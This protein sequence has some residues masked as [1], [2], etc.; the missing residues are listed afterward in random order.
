LPF[1]LAALLACALPSAQEPLAIARITWEDAAPVRTRLTAKGLS[2]DGF[3]AYVEKVHADNARRV[4]EGDLD[5]LVFYMLQS[6][7]FTSLPTIEPALS[8]KELVENMGNAERQ[9]FLSNGQTSLNRVPEPVVERA[10]ALQ[11][12]LN[13]PSRDLRVL[14]FREVVSAAFPN[15]ADRRAGVLRE[16]LRA[17]RFVYEKEF[18]A[19]RAVK[20]AEAVVE[21]YRTRGLSTDTE[22]EAGYLVSLGLG[23]LRA[24]DENRV[25]RRVLIVGPGLDIAPRTGLLESGPPESYQPWAVI[26]ALLSL[27]LARADS[28]E[29]VAADINPRVV[30][31]L[32]R[33]ASA[34]PLL[35]LVSGIAESDTVK[36]TDDYREYFKRLGAAIGEERALP[37]AAKNTHLTKSVR[38]SQAAA[39]TLHSEALDIVTDRFPGQTFDLVVATNI[40]PY[41]NDTDL[42]LAL[43][44]IATMLGP[45]GVFLHNEARPLLQEAAPALGLPAEQSRHAVIANVRGASTP[46]YDSVWLHRKRATP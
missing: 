46:L 16:Y 8:A 40:L 27:G 34:P 20:P 19:Q 39:R 29:V 24:L 28:L 33:A 45:G 30:A 7:A 14:Y 10:S 5:H 38:V 22:I 23:V 3:P 15:L 21:L 2:Q 32:R 1:V 25:V 9:A 6:T 26:D 17:M 4:R 37:A 12:A 11:R 36:L 31:H 35:T 13:G 41:F 42:L 18:V 44:N 43:T